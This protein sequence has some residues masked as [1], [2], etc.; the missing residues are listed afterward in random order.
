[1]HILSIRIYDSEIKV[2][3]TNPKGHLFPDFGMDDARS[4]SWKT[5]LLAP[6]AFIA[7][8]YNPDSEETEEPTAGRKK[9]RWIHKKN[10]QKKLIITNIYT[11]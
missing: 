7:V 2:V 3:I 8:V 9:K 4:R 10:R 1:M 5:L 6:A 11:H